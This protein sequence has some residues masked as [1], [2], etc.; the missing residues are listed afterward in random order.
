MSNE[1]RKNLFVKSNNQITIT[2]SD[3]ISD[4]DSIIKIIQPIQTEVGNGG[5]GNVTK[6]IKN[7]DQISNKDFINNYLTTPIKNAKDVVELLNSLSEG[8]LKQIKV[9]ENRIRDIENKR[10]V[11]FNNSKSDEEERRSL[12]KREIEVKKLEKNLFMKRN[13]KSIVGDRF[14]KDGDESNVQSQIVVEIDRIIDKKQSLLKKKVDRLQREK[15]RK[16]LESSINSNPII[17]RIPSMF[18]ENDVLTDRRQKLQINPEI[19]EISQITQLINDVEQFQIQNNKRI[20]S[21]RDVFE[22]QESDFDTNP[23]SSPSDI[24]ITKRNSDDVRVELEKY[25]KLI[26]LKLSLDNTNEEPSHISLNKP[27]R[28]TALVN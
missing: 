27:S 13:Y 3:E 25:K 7:I 21:H 11:D 28:G 19:Y 18:F 26:E 5:I 23:I 17:K 8:Q 12:F 10:K 24:L 4:S 16:E 1:L 9:Q 2:P 20:I 14:I 6:I 15:L 22:N